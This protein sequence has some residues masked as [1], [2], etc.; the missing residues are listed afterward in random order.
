MRNRCDSSSYFL[1]ATVYCFQ[2]GADSTCFCVAF[3]TP[4]CAWRFSKLKCIF[5]IFFCLFEPV[6]FCKSL[7]YHRYFITCLNLADFGDLIRTTFFILCLT[8]LHIVYCNPLQYNIFSH[9]VCLSVCAS[10][11]V[12]FSIPHIGYFA[13]YIFIWGSKQF[14]KR[15][16]FIMCII[17]PSSCGSGFHPKTG[18]EV[19]T[20]SEIRPFLFE[21][22]ES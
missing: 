17:S 15:V 12:S 1:E 2:V 7:Q 14:Q 5:T 20:F 11:C 21:N 3:C 22:T 4:Q 19:S 6:I 16:F 13:E 8:S 18:A 9:P 10:P